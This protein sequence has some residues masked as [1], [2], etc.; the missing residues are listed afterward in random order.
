[1]ATPNS[2][3][4]VSGDGS[5]FIQNLAIRGNDII[6]TNPGGSVNIVPSSTG[7]IA[8]GDVGFNA[9]VV[10]RSTPDTPLK[11]LSNGTNGTVWVENLKFKNNVIMTGTDTNENIVLSPNGT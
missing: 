3:L 5:V 9:G 11:M 6:A 8:F 1:M 2:N 10:T 7:Y 4:I